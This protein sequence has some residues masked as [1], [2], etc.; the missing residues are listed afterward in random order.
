MKRLCIVC[1]RGG[2]KGVPNKNIRPFAGKPLIAH[3]LGQ[4]ILTRL[5]DEVAVSSDSE[6][7]LDVARRHGATRLVR[8]PAELATDHADKMPAIVHCV[9]QVE[10]E[11]GV[12]FDTLVDLD[13]TAP[14]RFPEDIAAAVDRLETTGAPNLFS[15]CA[16]QRSPYYNMVE[17]DQEGRVRIVKSPEK[18]L[19][20]RQDAPPC[21]DMNASIYV[22]RRDAFSAPGDGLFFAGTEFYVMPAERSVDIDS[23]FDFAIAEFLFSRAGQAKA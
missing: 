12:A 7:I 9:R 22:W 19:V 6:E 18:P 21:Y 1:A 10:R 4:S 15:V 3:T 14:L 17:R 8:R 11:T 23:E 13:A 20:R 2:S 16:A 5:F